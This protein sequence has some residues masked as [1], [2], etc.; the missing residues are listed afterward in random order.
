MSL[1]VILIDDHTLFRVGL[2]VLLTS[3][4]IEVVASVGSGQDCLRLVDDLTPDIILLD[5]RMPGINGLG[6]ISWKSQRQSVVALSSCEAE[7][8]ALALAFQEGVYLKQLV[9]DI[10]CACDTCDVVTMYSDS[11]S[12]IALSQNPV[13]H[14]RSKHIDI[15][16]HFVREHVEN[17]FDL[18]YLPSECMLADFLT[19]PVGKAILQFVT[20]KIF[21]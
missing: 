17:D 1:R 16:Y 19:K 21:V 15:K 4:G 10:G 18:L 9:T 11:Q 3:R 7:Y 13:H 8:V 6:V 2:E 12:A 20:S 14:S 5:M